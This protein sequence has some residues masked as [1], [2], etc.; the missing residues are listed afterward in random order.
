MEE[1]QE[2]YMKWV[3]GKNQLADSLTKACESSNKLID[4]LEELPLSALQF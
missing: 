4:V 2:I 1:N 3:E